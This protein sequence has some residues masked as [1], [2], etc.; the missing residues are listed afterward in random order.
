MSTAGTSGQDLRE[1]RRMCAWELH[2][3]GWKGMDI[4]AAAACL[5]QTVVCYGVGN[6]RH[7]RAFAV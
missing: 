7:R 2:Q 6:R 5:N 3:E 1:W 4:A